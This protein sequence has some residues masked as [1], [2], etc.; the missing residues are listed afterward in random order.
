[1][2]GNSRFKDQKNEA[3]AGRVRKGRAQHRGVQKAPRSRMRTRDY[4]KTRRG[5]GGRIGNNGL[6]IG[7]VSKKGM[8]THSATN[9]HG[10]DEGG[11]GRG[12]EV[13]RTMTQGPFRSKP[14]GQGCMERHLPENGVRR[15]QRDAVCRVHVQSAK[16]NEKGP[17]VHLPFRV[18]PEQ[19][20][21][22]FHIG[23]G[24]RFGSH[25]VSV[26]RRVETVDWCPHLCPPALCDCVQYHALAGPDSFARRRPIGQPPRRAVQPTAHSLGSRIG[27]FGKAE[28]SG[29]VLAHAVLARRGGPSKA[30]SGVGRARGYPL[31]TRSRTRGQ[32]QA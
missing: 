9:S 31:V 11:M 10:D 15:W 19:Q 23:G 14:V 4:R 18:I 28:G 6:G 29:G 16:T 13:R 5:C 24:D 25:L 20:S 2:T 7:G 26:D 8:T 17:P 30:S 27:P 21:H 32:H 1:M 12:R 3:P 22:C